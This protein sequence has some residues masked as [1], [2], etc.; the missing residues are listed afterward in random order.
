MHLLAR[1]LPPKGCELS[2]PAPVLAAQPLTQAELKEKEDDRD[3]DHREKASEQPRA[4]GP[5][6]DL[7][8]DLAFGGQSLQDVVEFWRSPKDRS[9]RSVGAGA[10]A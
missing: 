1:R 7:L 3:H 10:P 4:P 6:G 5:G 8:Q 2:G 9:R